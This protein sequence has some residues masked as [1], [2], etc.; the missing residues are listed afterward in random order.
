[1]VRARRLATLAGAVLALALIC[2]SASLAGSRTT[3]PGKNVLVYFVI[4]DKDCDWIVRAFDEVI[5]GS[6]RVPGAIWSLGKTLIGHATR[7]RGRPKAL[8]PQDTSAN[9]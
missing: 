8:A 6:H 7:S 5:A 2:S 9:S 4:N 1:M 3:A